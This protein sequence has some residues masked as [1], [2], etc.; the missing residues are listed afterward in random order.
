MA[1][2]TR[3]GRFVVFHRDEVKEHVRLEGGPYFYKPVFAP[4]T[5][6][7]PEGY[8]TVHLAI[9]AAEDAEENA[10]WDELLPP[11]DTKEQPRKAAR[12]GAKAGA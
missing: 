6:A 10:P 4:M 11:V 12:A 9:D 2:L 7:S 1:E 5:A 8:P 3:Y